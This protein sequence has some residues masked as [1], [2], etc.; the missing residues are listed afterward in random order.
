MTEMMQAV[1]YETQ[2]AA[3]DVLVSG[4][5]PIPTP[6]PGE[7][8]V[9]LHA[10][11][12]NPSDV[13]V[14]AGS[15]PMAFSRIIPHSDGA[16]V[17][18][19]VGAGGDPALVG[20]RVFVR[21]G[22]W[23]RAHGTAAQFITL[24]AGC[25]HQLPDSVGFEVGAALGIPALTAAYAVLKD[26]PVDGETLLIHGGGGT[27]A[28]LAVQI[29]VD[30]GA[31][32]IATTG[33]MARADRIGDAGAVAVLDY[34]SP[35]L[36]GAVRAAAGGAEISRIIDPECGVNIEANIDLLA[37][38]GTIVGF[39]SVKQPSVDLPFLKMMFKN[40]TLSSILVYLLAAEEAAAYAAIVGDMLERGVLDVP[41]QDTLPL[42]QAARAHQ[43]VEAG[44]RSGAVLLA[45][46]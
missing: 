17:V 14:R 21:N 8:L 32:V 40:I 24:D 16:G 4:E 33:N 13:K 28:R 5:L 11:G 30:S 27:V 38:K 46:G 25:V 26:G 19:A 39:G 29:A 34:Q 22:Q 7:V 31:T 6:E 45:T 3:Q 35:D 41:V 2:G 37:A 15:R 20:A 12:V 43:L 23:Q 9:R 36:V 42:A 44:N 10:S 1:W 18:E